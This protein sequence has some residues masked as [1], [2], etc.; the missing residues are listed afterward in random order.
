MRFVRPTFALF[1]FFSFTRSSASWLHLL[2][3]PQAEK[4]PGAISFSFILLYGLEAP[5]EGP[6]ES[7]DTERIAFFDG[8][9]MR[10]KASQEELTEWICIFICS[11]SFVVWGRRTPWLDPICVLSITSQITL[12]IDLRGS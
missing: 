8:T 10:K 3:I 4:D 7:P 1:I 9:L 6:E 2:V 12:A 11:R 5:G